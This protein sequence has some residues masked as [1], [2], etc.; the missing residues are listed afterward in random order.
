[1]EVGYNVTTKNISKDLKPSHQH[2]V[3]NCLLFGRTNK[4]VYKIILSIIYSKLVGILN[5]HIF[6]ILFLLLKLLLQW[7]FVKS[8]LPTLFLKIKYVYKLLHYL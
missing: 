8:Y 5:Y 6:M 2:V 4:Y 7:V 1:M 3:I